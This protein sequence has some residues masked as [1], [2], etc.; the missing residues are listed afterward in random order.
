M[1]T[2]SKSKSR[3]LLEGLQPTQDLENA[4]KA[5]ESS[6]SDV[7]KAELRKFAATS[8][9]HGLDAAMQLTAS[10][11]GQ[12]NQSKRFKTVSRIQGFLESVQEF[13]AV[14]DSFA[15]LNPIAALVWSSLKVFILIGSR[16]TNFFDGLTKCLNAVQK[17]C[18]R[19]CEIQI[20]I[21]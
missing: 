16:F 12:K 8:D 5:F 10:A 21:S 15:G 4:L 13:A 7:N 1:S 3:R 2:V 20:S 11:E 17:H 9:I 19:F 6:L 14:I 18:P